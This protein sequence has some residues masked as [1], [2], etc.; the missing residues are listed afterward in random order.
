MV[1]A[2][3]VDVTKELA[4]ARESVLV[5]EW[6]RRSRSA[7]RSISIVRLP[8]VD[9]TWSPSRDL[10]PVD[11]GLT[12]KACDE[13]AFLSC[14]ALPTGDETGSGL[15]LGVTGDSG[16][17]ARLEMTD[18]AVLLL[19]DTLVIVMIHIQLPQSCEDLVS[20]I[21]AVLMLWLFT[22]LLISVIIT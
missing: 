22:C 9:S 19:L 10:L 14:D 4:V 2:P 17:F 5:L 16:I 20:K 18:W 13:L 15:F 3:D 21:E 7:L 6:C 8:A 11:L 12:P 1:P